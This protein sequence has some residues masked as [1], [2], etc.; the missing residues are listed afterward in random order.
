MSSII[1]NPFLGDRNVVEAAFGVPAGTVFT[2]NG[3][4]LNTS[5]PDLSALMRAVNSAKATT[6]A[7]SAPSTPNTPGTQYYPTLDGATG[8][9]LSGKQ[10]SYLSPF[11]FYPTM[12]PTTNRPL[13]SSQASYYSEL[14]PSFFRQ[15][16]GATGNTGGVN[17]DKAFADAI[18]NRMGGS[19]GGGAPGGAGGMPGGMGG[20]GGAS[21]GG[22]AALAQQMAEKAGQADQKKKERPIRPTEESNSGP[23]YRDPRLAAPTFAGGSGMF[24]DSTHGGNVLGQLAA[25]PAQAPAPT[26]AP[27]PTPKP[28]TGGSKG[29]GQSRGRWW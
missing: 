19:S 13:T 28:T 14:P 15:V 22:M 9:P 18:R 25:R 27:K 21:A 1:N 5:G 11:Q 7:T 26:P 3:Q 24:D 8:Q 6:A 16:T 10:A 23:N 29:G 12:D 4:T 17:L 2:K 20:M